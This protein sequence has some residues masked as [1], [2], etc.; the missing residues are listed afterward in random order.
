MNL[1]GN[2]MPVKETIKIMLAKSDV[3]LTEVVKRLNEKRG[4][5]DTVQNLSKKVNK[6]TLRYDEVE[7][8][9]EV[10]GYRLDWVPGSKKNADDK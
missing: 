4:T 6:G 9:A 2:K 7:E 10:L 8:I 5:N 1:G 3:T